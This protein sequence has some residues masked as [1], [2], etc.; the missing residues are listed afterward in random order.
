MSID[1][2][3]RNLDEMRASLRDET[4]IALV[5]HTPPLTSDVVRDKDWAAKHPEDA[6]RY[7]VAP[8]EEPAAALGMTLAAPLLRL[9]DNPSGIRGLL[10][11]WERYCRGKHQRWPDHASG[12]ICS[13]IAYA[14]I[15]DGAGLI[16]TAEQLGIDWLRAERLLSLAVERMNAWADQPHLE[17]AESHDREA[18]PSCRRE[19]AA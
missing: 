6:P 2:L 17:R 18:C 19:D 9:L 10:R 14:V 5:S 15:R 7:L 13:Q 4:P 1:R 16:Y 3:Y 12:P 8:K 11:R